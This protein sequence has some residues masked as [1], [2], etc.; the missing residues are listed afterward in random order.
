MSPVAV[1]KEDVSAEVVEQELKIAKEKFRQEG[2]PE[3]ML[4]K[5]AQG[6]LNKFF[7]ENT[8]LN[9]IYVK[10]GKITISQFLA[11]TDK[12]LKVTGFKR[13]TLNA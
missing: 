1:D 8:L 11:N 13:F 2:K 10:D 6:S 7:K 5:I 12:E 4:D 9:Q 3:A